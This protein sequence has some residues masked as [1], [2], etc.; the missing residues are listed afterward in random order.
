[1]ELVTHIENIQMEVGIRKSVP[2]KFDNLHPGDKQRL[3]LSLENFS[4][5]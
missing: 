5:R 3:F 1:M 2:A 4:S